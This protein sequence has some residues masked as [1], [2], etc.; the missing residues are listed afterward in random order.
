MSFK[1]APL[2]QGIKL[3]LKK[4]GIKNYLIQ[5]RNDEKNRTTVAVLTVLGSNT[6]TDQ[7]TITK[8]VI[9]TR[10]GKASIASSGKSL[11]SDDEFTNKITALKKRYQW[12]DEETEKL[13]GYLLELMP[14]PTR[15]PGMEALM[16]ELDWRIAAEGNDAVDEEIFFQA[17]ESTVPPHLAPV[18]MNSIKHYSQ[19]YKAGTVPA[20]D[21]QSPNELYQE[22]MSKSP[23][24]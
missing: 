18:M 22:I 11:S 10:E 21:E 4:S 9:N 23:A 17:L 5:Y 1:N 2:E 14:E 8:E 19:R 20:A 16:D 24:N 6:K 13:A 12:T 15:G 7:K 3:L